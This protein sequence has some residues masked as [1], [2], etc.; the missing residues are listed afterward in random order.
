[1]IMTSVVGSAAEIDGRPVS[2]RPPRRGYCAAN[3]VMD[4][5]HK[6]GRP[7]QTDA[8]HFGLTHLAVV[9]A[10]NVCRIVGTAQLHTSDPRRSH[11]SVRGNDALLGHPLPQQGVLARREAV[12]GRKGQRLIVVVKSVQGK[13]Q[14]SASIE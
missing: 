13:D 14:C 7:G 1:M 11:E 8:A 12:A 2:Q 10:F 3:H 6:I 9:H 5:R 4:A